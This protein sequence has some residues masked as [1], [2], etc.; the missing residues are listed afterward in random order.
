M[1]LLLSMSHMQNKRSSSITALYS[2]IKFDTIL[3]PDT[4]T[5]L[6]NATLA[7]AALTLPNIAIFRNKLT[8]LLN[9]VTGKR[10]NTVCLFCFS[11]NHI[12]FLGYLRGCGGVVVEHRTPNREVLGWIPTCGTVLCP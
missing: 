5:S 1:S 9:F 3:L 10:D 7:F 4:Y 12:V 6:P 8:T 2:C 11:R